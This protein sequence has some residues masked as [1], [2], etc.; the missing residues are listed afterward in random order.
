MRRARADGAHRDRA[1]A[2]A[3]LGRRARPAVAVFG[4]GNFARRA[5]A[6]R[7]RGDRAADPRGPRR[8]TTGD[9]PRLGA[10]RRQALSADVAADR[11]RGRR[12]D[13]GSARLDGDLVASRADD[14]RR[15]AHRRGV[16]LLRQGPR[17]RRPAG[18]R[19]RR[20]CVPALGRH[21]LAGRGV[22]DDA[23]RLPRAVRPLPQLSD[24]VARLAGE[25]ARA[26]A[27]AHAVPVRLAAAARAVRRDPAAG[28]ARGAA[29]AARG[30]LPPPD[31]ADRGAM[32]REPRAGARHRRS[33][34]PGRVADAREPDRDHRGGDAAGAAAAHRHG[35]G[36]DHRGGAAARHLSD[37]DHSRIRTAARCSPRSI[38]RPSARA[39]TSNAA[40]AALPIDEMVARAIAGAVRGGVFVSRYRMDRFSTVKGDR[41]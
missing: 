18:R 24:P 12:P 23:A 35:Q 5:R 16:L 19:E 11:A 22:A 6:A 34:R 33:G 10:P 31:D 7:R 28:R 15:G 3:R 21:R 17:R 36:G 25:G 8:P 9:V 26:G 30:A 41:S 37:L 2:G 29:A 38:R 14:P 4:V 1:R 39:A 40:E 27:A 32:A 20:A 13:Q